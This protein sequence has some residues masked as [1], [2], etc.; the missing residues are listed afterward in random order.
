MGDGGCVV[1]V[2]EA[3]RKFGS[4]ARL[5]FRQELAPKPTSAGSYF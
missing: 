5:K 4:S 2:D 3:L 1:D